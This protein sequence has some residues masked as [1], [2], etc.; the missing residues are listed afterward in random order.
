[1]QLARLIVNG[2]FD[3]FEHNVHF[4]DT[5][6]KNPKP[7]VVV[8]HGPNG[9]GKTTVLRML[10]GLMRLDFNPFRKVPFSY[11]S[12]SFTTG[13]SISIE[14]VKNGSPVRALRVRFEEH[15][16]ILSGEKPGALL[17]EHHDKVEAFRTEFLRKTEDLK[18][19]FIDT[20]RLLRQSAIDENVLSQFGIAPDLYNRVLLRS[21]N[22][23]AKGPQ[24]EG[25][26][27]QKIQ[28]F[29]R[30][31]QLNYR[32]FFSTREPDLFPRILQHITEQPDTQYEPRD[33]LARLDTVHEKD[34]EMVRFGLHP[35]QWNYA[36]LSTF[37][38][39]PRTQPGMDSALSA[40][41]AYVDMLESRLAER[42][43]VAERL[44][45][46]E[47]VMKN[48][49]ID[50]SVTV[51]RKTGLSI[52]TNTGANLKEDQLSSG[53]YHLL[54]LMVAALTTRRRGTIVA[55]DEPEMSMH[56]SWQRKLVGA[57]IKCASGAEPQ[58]I[59]ATHSP[60]I[61]AEFE[62]NL[63]RLAPGWG[64]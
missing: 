16:V 3:Q 60:D 25:D 42:V 21:A 36:S 47:E 14:T 26:L 59:F 49:L 52:T 53:E 50:K 22:P 5:D 39:L 54:Y 61:A 30:E 11:C 55:I 20:G 27:A 43:L 13:E 18:F 10:D 6:D 64:E 62:E 58:F 38:Q 7:S 41:G 46:F 35:D 12:L 28:T 33:L 32:S 44:Q 23:K 40:L 9:V 63:I 17:E 8:L 31:A 15:E 24:Q 1:M 2:L 56:I 19:D 34:A 51:D 48:F 57:L 45:T 4:P 29:I 37:L